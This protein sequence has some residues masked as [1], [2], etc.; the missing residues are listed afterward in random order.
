MFHVK[1]S[2]RQSH[3]LEEQN[4]GLLGV[5]RKLRSYIQLLEV[6]RTALLGTITSLRHLVNSKHSNITL[7]TD[8]S[9]SPP[10]NLADI[11]REVASLM[12]VHDQAASVVDNIM[13]KIPPATD[14]SSSHVTALARRGRPSSANY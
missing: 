5:E 2:R 9:D 6:E 1:A 4:A 3:A 11:D 10:V 14:D 12:E 8:T 7:S 13:L